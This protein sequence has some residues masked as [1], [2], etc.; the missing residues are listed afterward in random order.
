VTTPAPSQQRVIALPA[1]VPVDKSLAQAGLVTGRPVVVLIGGAAKLD[2][3]TGDLRAAIRDGVMV[4]AQAAGATVVDGGTDSGVMA[5]AGQVRR[6]LNATIPLVG[7]A[8]VAKVSAPGVSAARG[9]TGLEP[10]HTH[11]LLAPG[12]EWGSEAPWL[13]STAKILGANRNVVAVLV[14]GGPLALQEA[15]ACAAQG[16]PLVV[17]AGSGRTA[18]VLAEFARGSR[19]GNMSLDRRGSIHVVDLAAGAPAL[20]ETLGALL[21]GQKPAASRPD[22]TA[23]P[24]RIDYPA[25]Y[26]AASA[27]SKSG[28]TNFKRLNKLGL[29]LTVGALVVGALASLGIVVVSFREDERNFIDKGV[30]I[31]AAAVFLLALLF[32]LLERSSSYD[33][34]WFHGRAIAETVKS[35]SWRYMMRVPPFDGRDAEEQMTTELATML[36]SAAGIRQAVDQLPAQA[37]QI[38]PSMREVRE[39]AYGDRRDF[40]IERRLLEQARWYRQRSARHRRAATRWFW[41]SV[42]FQVFAIVAA[43]LALVAVAEAGSSSPRDLETMFLK[44]MTLAASAAIAVTAWTQLNRDDEL[45]KAYGVSLQELLLI[46]GAAGRATSDE[47]FTPVVRDGEQAIGRENSVWVA[48]RS[49]RYESPEFGHLD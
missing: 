27:A 31:V 43:L 33:D 29:A 44:G 25:L 13:V 7:V 1:N 32:K 40:Y 24:A 37:E 21:R 48:K 22:R 9:T 6:D 20:A 26:V 36:D 30:V 19:D 17:L 34:D 38:S 16:W 18:D 15:M 23:T 14:D 3:T 42:I 8:P 45:A 47:T 2:E 49:E 11:V 10:N 4:T 41:M 28:Q 12:D 5:I 39:R 35:L 46:A